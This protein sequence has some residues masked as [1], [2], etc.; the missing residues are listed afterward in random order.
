[1]GMCGSGGGV[2]LECIS[3]T[4]EYIRTYVQTSAYEHS[5]TFQIFPSSRYIDANSFLP[6]IDASGAAVGN[7]VS[8]LIN[9]LTS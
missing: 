9:L 6:G 5:S 1:M 3:S 8:Q 2:L 4:Y 7:T